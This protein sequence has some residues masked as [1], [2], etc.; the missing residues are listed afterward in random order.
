MP[1]I[2]A[3]ALWFT[4]HALSPFNEYLRDEYRSAWD[5]DDSLDNYYD[6]GMEIKG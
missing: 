3:F 2:I 5:D 6:F 1:G 4:G